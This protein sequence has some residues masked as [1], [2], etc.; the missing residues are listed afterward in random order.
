MNKIIIGLTLLLSFSVFGEVHNITENCEFFPIGTYY[1]APE[2]SEPTYNNDIWSIVVTFKTNLSHESIKRFGF[3]FSSGKEWVKDKTGYPN[4]FK[5]SQVCTFKLAYHINSF[6]GIYDIDLEGSFFIETKDGKYYWL[7]EKP[8]QNMQ[9]NPN[10][11]LL[12]SSKITEQIDVF[13]CRDKELGAGW[14]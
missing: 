8:L 11:E 9:L 13:N 4:C 7:Q 3:K 5:D 14:R 10:G 12:P 6:T 1:D 2:T